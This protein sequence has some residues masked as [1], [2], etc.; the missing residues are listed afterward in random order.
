MQIHLTY[1]GL[2]SIIL[3]FLG[4]A[5]D[6]DQLAASVPAASV[7]LVAFAR[8]FLDVLEHSLLPHEDERPALQQD[9]VAAVVLLEGHHVDDHVGSPEVEH[10]V[11][12]VVLEDEE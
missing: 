9:V 3:Q 5:A 10:V 6:E 7:S 11:H 2:Q 1:N 12:H 4:L 8:P